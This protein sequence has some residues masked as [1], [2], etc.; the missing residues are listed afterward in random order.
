MGV[1]EFEPRSSRFRDKNA[2]LL[3]YRTNLQIAKSRKNETDSKS[4]LQN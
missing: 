4:N 2:N 1:A 3:V